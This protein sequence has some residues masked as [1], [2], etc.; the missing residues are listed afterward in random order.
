V[1][2]WLSCPTSHYGRAITE[3]NIRRLVQIMIDLDV[4]ETVAA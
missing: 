1:I 2:G 4:L 3:E